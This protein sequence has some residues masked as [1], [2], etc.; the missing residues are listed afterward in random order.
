MKKQNL[1]IAL[2]FTV[3]TFQ[4]FG[5]ISEAQ[6]TMPPGTMAP[7]TM[8]P[9]TMAPGT[10]AP[11]TMAPGTMAPGT[12]ASG[13]DS[14]SSADCTQNPADGWQAVTE[15]RSEADFQIGFTDAVAG[16]QY[17]KFDNDTSIV[18][19]AG[20]VKDVYVGTGAGSSNLG[21]FIDPSMDCTLR[22]DNLP[23]GGRGVHKLIC[24]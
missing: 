1:F 5:N 9:G 20:E 15:V 11:G 17:S 22:N 14:P 24:P 6:N 3:F 19:V 18:C 21:M 10:M 2:F 13:T 23:S 8:A 4:F 16:R 12:M 7:G